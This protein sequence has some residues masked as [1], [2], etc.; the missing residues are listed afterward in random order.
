MTKND[1]LNFPFTSQTKV[2]IFCDDNWYGVAEVDFEREK[3]GLDNGYYL[4]ISQIK[5]I[6]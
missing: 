2:L 3:I 5:E 6:K 4:G 1:F